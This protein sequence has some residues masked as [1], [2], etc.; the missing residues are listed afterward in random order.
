MGSRRWSNLTKIIVAITLAVLALILLITFRVLITPTIVAFL[1][2]FILGYP[3]NWIQRSTGWARSISVALT[4][5]V[6]LLVLV[7]MPVL[8]LPRF[9]DLA[10]SLQATL[11]G[12]VEDLRNVSTGPIFA[13][14]PINF[15][16]DMLIQQAGEML[17]NLLVIA[18]GNPLTLARGLTNSLITVVYVLVLN[19]WLLKD[20][21]KLQRLA[22]DQIPVDY[23]EDARRL[24]LE[25]RQIW[26]AFMRGQLTLAIV[27]ALLTWIA[28]LI[29]GMPNA[30]AL[31]LL[32]GVLEFLPSIGPAISGTIGTVF[33]LFQGSTWLPANNLTFAIVVGLI[34]GIIGQL[35]GIYLIPRLVGG[36]VRL[37]PALAF[38]GVIAGTLVFGLLGVLLAMPIMASART[39]LSYVYRKLFDLEPFEP[40]RTPQASI[41][42]PGL[43]AGRKIDAIL[44]DLDGT[45]ADLDWSSPNWARTH[46]H[47]MNDLVTPER[48]ARDIRRLMVS[49]EGVINF[50]VSQSRRFKQRSEIDD[51]IHWLNQLRGHPPASDLTPIPGVPEMIEQLATQYRL[52][53]VSTRPRHEIYK[54]LE[55]AD[56]SPDLFGVLIGREDTGNLLPHGEPLI[57]ATD[58]LLLEAN[59]ILMVSDTDSNL[60]SARAIE[61]ATV[62]V[63]CG[64]GEESDLLESDLILASTP[65]LLDWLWV[66][67]PQLS[68]LLRTPQ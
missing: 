55:R 39:I 13:F 29:V 53:I 63:L 50:L 8:I 65:E 25:L 16:P 54:F 49:V 10:Q 5:V 47:W 66:P 43:I 21:Y 58:R 27:V 7:L 51:E 59:Q 23:Q 2:A 57:A 28:L 18:T 4:Y 67:S 37:H 40:L 9:A 15:S 42:I 34:Y 30:G 46:L 24:G 52:G 36:Q 1:L 38:V 22:M 20:S 56:L 68:S 60:R 19:F 41:R 26:H 31:A 11:E 17:G 45:L 48:R 33:A 32:A 62:G 44:F 61:M 3:V 35:E 64:L 14:G 12:L 6:L